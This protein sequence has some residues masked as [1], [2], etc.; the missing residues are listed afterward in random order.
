MM[1][2]SAAAVPNLLSA[3]QQFHN[4]GDNL[5]RG[6]CQVRS[7]QMSGQHSHKDQYWSLVNHRLP[8][9]PPFASH[10]PT[11]VRSHSESAISASRRKLLRRAMSVAGVNYCAGTISSASAYT[12]DRV[13]ADERDTFAEVQQG[14]GPL[15]ILWVGSGNPFKGVVV[16]NLFLPGNEVIALDLQRPDASDLAAATTYAAEHGYR[17]CFEQGDATKLKFADETFDAAVSS[18]FLCQDFPGGPEVVISE[19]RRVLKPGGRFGFY[20]HIE[21]I[22]RVIVD[23]VFGERSVLRVQAYPERTNVIAGVVTKV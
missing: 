13:K 8:S 21:D 17:L 20:E 3:S 19:I 12:I 22:D 5:S 15:R 23:K 9:G 2:L 1:I 16:K 10:S 7:L 18:F 11:A 14:N 6:T 4:I